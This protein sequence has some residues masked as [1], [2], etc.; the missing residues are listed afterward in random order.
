MQE[1]N[2][3]VLNQTS[4]RIDLFIVREKKTFYADH[5]I[6]DFSKLKSDRMYFIYIRK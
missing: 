1:K 3:S 4:I 6:N 5:K 2:K